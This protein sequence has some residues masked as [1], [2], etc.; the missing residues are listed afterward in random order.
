MKGKDFSALQLKPYDGDSFLIG[1][2]VVAAFEV[3]HF[4]AFHTFGFE[5]HYV[6]GHSEAKLVVASDFSDWRGLVEQ[7]HDSDFIYI[8]CNHDP[9]PLRLH[10]NPNSRRHLRNEKCG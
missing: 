3:P 8:E 5:C 2:L 4:G 9:E 1:D 6:H 7:F 10:P